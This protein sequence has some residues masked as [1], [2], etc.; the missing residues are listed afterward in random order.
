MESMFEKHPVFEEPPETAHIWRYMSFGKYVSLLSRQALYFCRADR[1]QDMY[2]GRLP[3]PT[4]EGT[5]EWLRAGYDDTRHN[6]ILNCWSLGEYE[7]VA[8]WHIYVPSREGVAIRSSFGRLKDSFRAEGMFQEARAHIGLVCYIDFNQHDF[9]GPDRTAFNAFIPLMHKRL[10]FE[11]ERE[12]RAVIS[13]LG[14]HFLDSVIRKSEGLYVPISLSGLIESVHVAPEAP[15]W[16]LEI[17]RHTTEFHGLDPALVIQS[18]LDEPPPGY[19][20][21]G[22]D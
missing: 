7:S 6:T 5:H 14:T 19:G 1:L 16:F 17:V 11:Y 2:E 20:N 3:K 13:G 21:A 12:V 4:Y 9:V 8:L 10:Y 22:G 15:L 18:G